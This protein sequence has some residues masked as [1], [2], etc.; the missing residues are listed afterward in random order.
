MPNVL[1]ELGLEEV[2]ARFIDQCLADVSQ[3]LLK[4]IKQHRLNT[5][6]TTI[7]TYGTYRRFA[8]KM[9]NI[10]ASQDDMDTVI[11]GPP[12]AIAKSEG[13]EWLPPAIGFAKKCDVSLDALQ[14]VENKKGQRVVCAKQFQL[15]QPAAALLPIIFKESLKA[16]KLPIAMVWGDNIGPFIRPVKWVCSMIDE[17]PIKWS[18]FGVESSNAT[19]G[20]RFLTHSED[21]SSGAQCVIQSVDHYV[22][23]LRGQQVLVDVK[24]RK[25]PIR[26][27]L[28]Q[29]QITIDEG[30]L[31]EVTHLTEYP[32][33]L[34]IAFPDSF[35]TLPKEVL[36][37]CLKKHQKAFM[38][39]NSV[40]EL[41][42]ECLVVADSVTRENR[43]QIIEGNQRVMMARL[44][45]VQF[46]WEEDLK[47]NGFSKWNKK[48]ASIVFQ[49][50]LGTM[51]DKVE[52]VC[53]IAHTI[54]DQL[55]CSKDIRDIVD[56]AAHRAKADLVS[57]MVNELP[58]LQG[59]MGSYY[60]M[61]FKEDP[62][63]VLAIRD[64]YNPRFDGDAFPESLH[65][66]IIAIA[67]RLDTMVSCFE[68]NAI[69][70]GSR[71][72]WGIR[73]SMIAIT[74]MIFYFQL[75]LNLNLLLED[76]TITLDRSIGENTL[77]CSAFFT[78]RIESVFQDE[79]IPPDIIQLFKDQLILSPLT[80]YEQAK[81]LV[82]LKETSPMQYQLLIETTARVSK[83][84]DGYQGD[85]NV[86]NHFFENDIEK[87]A[88]Q[89]FQSLKSKTK[90]CR[91]TAEGLSLSVSFCE[92]LS[93]YFDNILINAED[94]NIAN[95]RRSFI[96]S[97]NDYF[98]NA[99]DWLKLQK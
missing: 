3:H 65:G 17:T 71:D 58:S 53:H 91:L 73:R 33:V 38:V 34:A 40:G 56:R 27:A 86:S 5:D 77:K 10:L 84:I 36:T 6:Q 44:N 48:L 23:S 32:T 82:K 42:N 39:T 19:F 95:N 64:H 97:V 51:A 78:T 80:S 90:Q 85:S 31:N 15:G 55:G 87:E 26:A 14:E 79:H 45:D 11:E 37:Q 43:E 57:Q 12:I 61:C 46:F 25:E 76:A 13:G 99:G 92:T 60:A 88:Y 63:V 50:N 8:F 4:Q 28:D 69:P 72:P 22:D 66:V 68:N 98:F 74:R 52:R 62:E 41:K 35:L 20:H 81:E 29:R 7:E 24:E 49:E 93:H 54:M 30:L 67:D 89:S 70:T 83:I 47:N 21:A 75:P 1:L 59:V 2:P 18:F 96:K 94:P 9:S 16:M